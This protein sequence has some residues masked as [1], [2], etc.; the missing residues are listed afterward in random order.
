MRAI[1]ALME[2]KFRHV[3]PPRK[4]SNSINSHINRVLHI[5]LDLS[6]ALVLSAVSTF[7]SVVFDVYA[8]LNIYLVF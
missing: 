3:F 2:L 6:D 8:T 5:F 1:K 4:A 7:S